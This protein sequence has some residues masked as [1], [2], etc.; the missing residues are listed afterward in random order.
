MT[1]VFDIDAKKGLARIKR[2]KD[3][4]EKRAVAYHQ[5]VRAGY[6]SLAKKEPQRIKVIDAA[7]SLQQVQRQISDYLAELFA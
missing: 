5:R 4:I 1:F 2:S 6:L 7:Q 3:R